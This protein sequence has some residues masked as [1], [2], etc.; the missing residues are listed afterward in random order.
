MIRKSRGFTLI[1]LLVVIAIIAVLIALL[2]PAVQAARE[3]A[4]RSQ[5]TNNLKQLGLAVQNYMAA[6]TLVP[7][8][9]VDAPWSSC[10]GTTINEP[11]QNF[12]Q[13]TRLLPYLEQTS[14]FNSLNMTFG[15]RWN[16]NAPFQQDV[17]QATVITMQ[18]NA[19][20]CPSDLAPGS[21]AYETVNGVQ[22]LVGALSYP[23]NVGLNRRINQAPLNNPCG[24]SWQM[25]GPNYIASTWDGI[26]KRMI[27]MASFTDGTSQTAIY[28]EWVKG[29]GTGSPGKDGLGMVYKLNGGLGS[30]AFATDVQFAQ[31]CAQTQFNTTTQ[32]TGW[33]GE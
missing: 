7:P 26:G 22:K 28:S 5:C 3:A 32:L 16:A 20:L 17:V 6:Q 12:S 2:L 33:K 25:N 9:N 31:A 30:N 29:P 21:S 10:N 23:A 18:I 14:A 15:A 13:Q 19:F 11:Y 1:E 4:R 24:G 8:L 27:S